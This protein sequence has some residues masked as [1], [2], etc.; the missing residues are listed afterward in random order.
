M[1]NCFNS[2]FTEVS[3]KI[4]DEI[5]PSDLSPDNSF[6]FDA[7]HFSLSNN[8]VTCTEII[9]T[10][11]SLQPKKTLDLNGISVWLLQKVVNAIATPLQH[12]FV[13]SFSKGIVPQQLKIAKVVPIFK[14][15]KKDCMDNYRPISLLSSFSKIIE[16]IVATR[17]TNFLDSNNLISNCQY[18]FR[19][20][21]STLHPLVHFLNDVSCALDRKEHT[22]AIFCDLRKAF[23]TV[24]HCILLSK[25]KKL[26]VRNVELQWFKNYLSNRKQ[27]VHVNGENSSLLDILIGVP[28]GS[29]LGPLLFLIYI[30]DLPNCSSLLALLFADDTTLY[31]SDSNLNN[32]IERVNCEFKKVVDNFRLLKLALHPSKTKFILFTNSND[33]RASNVSISLNFNNDTEAQDQNLISTLVRVTTESEIPAIKFLGIFIDPLLS[34]KYHIN[35][36]V[37]KVSKSLYFLRATKNVLTPAALK[38]VY[39]ALVHSHFIYGIQIWSSTTASNL[40]GLFLKPKIAIR[41]INSEMCNA[42]TEP[43]FKKSNILPLHMLVDY[44]KLQFFHRFT[45]ND[46]PHSFENTWIKNEERRQENAPLLRNHLEYHVPYSRLSSTEKFPLICFPRLWCSFSDI[47]IKSTVNKSSFNI[48][49]KNYFINSLSATYT[50]TRLLCPRCHLQV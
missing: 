25:L 33:A 5:H 1:A 49:L 44:F 30:N 2:F 38:S 21:H 22:V 45:I 36:I 41:L 18:G 37:S 35:T 24:S 7:P 26:G 50:C 43:L 4:V 14:S 9:E 23:D 12:I 29:I 27:L 48:Q 17:L 13:Q 39:Y 42:H 20:N 16:K 47:N 40:N 28:Q 34:F 3:S 31:L 10:I 46:L 15:G 6:R 32:L 8:P 19:K 11:Q